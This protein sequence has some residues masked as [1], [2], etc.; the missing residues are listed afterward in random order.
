MKPIGIGI[1]NESWD[2]KLY[3]QLPITSLA[4]GPA[5]YFLHL[6]GHLFVSSIDQAP[7]ST[8]RIKSA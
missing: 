6:L 8:I 7:K 3:Q 2:T 4:R 1:G 5:G